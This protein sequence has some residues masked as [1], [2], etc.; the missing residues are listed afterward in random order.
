MKKRNTGEFT[1][2][3][4]LIVI[5]IIAILAAMLL[6]ALAKVRERVRTTECLSSLKQ[7]GIFMGIYNSDYRGFYPPLKIGSSYSSNLWAKTLADL[8]MSG[9][10]YK[11]Y[12][13]K[14]ACPSKKAPYESTLDPWGVTYGMN[15]YLASPDPGSV[16]FYGYTHAHPGLW[17][18]PA[19]TVLNNDSRFP[20]LHYKAYLVSTS[21]ATYQWGHNSATGINILCMDGHAEFILTNKQTGSLALPYFRNYYMWHSL[22]IPNGP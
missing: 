22:T 11:Q 20:D 5:A 1:L 3:E 16:P 14:F 12:Y 15:A 7:V 21:Y 17:K 6:P 13:K 2:I 4:L 18:Y 9:L 8:Y 10:S 19:R